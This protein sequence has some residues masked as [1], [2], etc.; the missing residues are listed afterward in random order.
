M[1]TEV[2]DNFDAQ[3]VQISNIAED[4]D[5]VKTQVEL[6]GE[7]LGIVED[8]VDIWGHRITA[9]EVSNVDVINRLTTVEDIILGKVTC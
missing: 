1:L 6:Q 8:D 3:Q 9:L 7:R 5:L 4:V 2:E